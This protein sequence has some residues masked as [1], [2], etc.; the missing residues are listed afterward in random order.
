[1]PNPAE[2]QLSLSLHLACPVP[3]TLSIHS[4]D[5]ESGVQCVGVGE[6]WFYLPPAGQELQ[7]RGWAIS[8]LYLKTFTNIDP[9][10]HPKSSSQVADIKAA[11]EG[12]LASPVHITEMQ[13]KEKR[14]NPYFRAH[15]LGASVEGGWEKRVERAHRSA[16][17]KAKQGKPNEKR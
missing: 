6:A 9:P 2:C 1:M 12:S 13:G 4:P 3:A 17:L 15:S 11:S 8:S 16:C 14:P 10:S 5:W 7:E